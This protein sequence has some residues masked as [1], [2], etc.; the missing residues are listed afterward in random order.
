MIETIDNF[1]NPVMSAVK[2]LRKQGDEL[3]KSGKSIT[4]NTIDPSV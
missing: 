3:A 2:T 4:G 1:D